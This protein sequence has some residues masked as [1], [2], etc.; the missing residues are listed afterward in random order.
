MNSV[1]GSLALAQP[2]LLL[3]APAAPAPQVIL[4]NPDDDAQAGARAVIVRALIDGAVPGAAVKQAELLRR[5]ALEHGLSTRTI[6]RW[7]SAYIR[8]GKAALADKGRNDKGRSRFFAAYRKAAML[9]A[10]LYLDQKQSVSV[11]WEQL[12]RQADILGIA[13]EDKPSYST[14]RVFLG[15]EIS[16]AM[17]TLAREGAKVY[18]ERVAP[19]LKRAYVDVAAN[20]WWI[21]DHSQ[22][23]VE[24]ANDLFDEQ[25]LGTP[26]RLRITGFIDYRSR[27]VVGASWAWE[28]SSRSIAASLK[29]GVMRY[30][31]PEGIY[32]DNGVDMKKAA[33][34][35]RRG[36]APA[37]PQAPAWYDVEW[38]AIEKTGFLARL[39]IAVTHALPFHPQSKGIERWFKTL[40]ERFDKVHSTYT[41]G[42]PATRPASTESAM[43]RHRRLLKAGRVAE[44]T[45]PW[46]SRFILGCLSYIEEFN[47]TAHGGEGMDGQT[48]DQVFAANLNPNQ[49]PAPEP[50][51]LA[52]LLAEWERR[53]V[54]ECAITL[55]KH[56]YMPRPEDRAG[57]AALHEK[58]GLDVLI[59]YD[60]ADLFH[61][62][63]L[64]L[65][66]RFL[67]WLEAEELIRFAPGDAQ[68]QAQIAQSMSIRRGLE[69]ATRGALKAIAT[70]ARANGAQTA[71]ELLYGR[72][73]IVDSHGP[74]IT[75]RKQHQEPPAP[76]RL[77]P[78][79][80]AARLAARLKKGQPA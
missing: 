78:G 42:S 30:G 66:G 73:Q 49:K 40:H 74:V 25:P 43:M 24:V 46:A 77:L 57:W 27:K 76:E 45:H 9:A 15:G 14:V 26:I 47:A 37:E 50:A 69:K 38:E 8:E 61:A 1:N 20:A 63:A 31:P 75:Q 39:G 28:G 22:H 52:M 18:R 68:V 36:G 35:A 19:Y 23:D 41:S 62:A 7:K 13:A 48:P 6:L 44:T 3:C 16:P 59:A 70:E 58:N 17:R 12:V 34:G 54:R 60:P 55:R 29:R 4:P 11:V 5:L 72:L 2:Q 32:T 65:D 80:A 56:R 33:K 53:S 71:E 21:L 51:A 64:D 79:D 67:A 10:F